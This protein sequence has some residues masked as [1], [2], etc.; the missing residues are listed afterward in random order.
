MAKHIPDKGLLS[1][2][3][4]EFSELDQKKTNQKKGDLEGISWSMVRIHV[5]MAKGPR[6]IPGRELRSHKLKWPKEAKRQIFE[7]N[8]KFR[9]KWTCH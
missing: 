5:F 8:E 3:Y 7:K 9:E 6:P 2:M 1:T 4:K